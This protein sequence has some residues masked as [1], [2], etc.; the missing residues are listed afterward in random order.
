MQQ[1]RL[2]KLL[3]AP[4]V[5]EKST[6]SAERDKHFVFKVAPDATKAEIKRAV[7]LMFDVK[8]SAV[9]VV[10]VKGKRK[11]FGRTMGKRAGWKKAYV[12]LMPGHD[13]ELL[14]AQ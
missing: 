11:R 4:H 14:G 5:S 1:E 8:V 3:L 7:E 2:M 10:N 6:L 9:Q 12:N 13:I